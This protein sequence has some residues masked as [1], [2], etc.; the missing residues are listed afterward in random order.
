MEER[1]DPEE[2][3]PRKILVEVEERTNLMVEGA[4]E[5]PF[6]IVVLKE[7][8]EQGFSRTHLP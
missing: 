3:V 4:E 7:V 5:G 8:Q 6:L 1:Y 2:V